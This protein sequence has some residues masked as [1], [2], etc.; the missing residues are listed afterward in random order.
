[1]DTINTKRN[2]LSTT[3]K[4]F[5]GLTTIGSL[6][7]SYLVLAV[8]SGSLHTWYPHALLIAVIVTAFCVFGLYHSRGIGLWGM[9]TFFFLFASALAT[10]LSLTSLSI[11]WL[12]FSMFMFAAFV[13]IGIIRVFR[14]Y[15]DKKR[16]SEDSAV[17]EPIEVDISEDN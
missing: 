6:F 1:M 10:M 8:L 14:H 11:P 4:I 16:S 13:A 2:N 9:E 3:S 7:L 17:Q 12:I 5:W 15:S